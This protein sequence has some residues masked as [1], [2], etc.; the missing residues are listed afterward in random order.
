MLNRPAF[1]VVVTFCAGLS[2]APAPT[3]WAQAEN[4]ATAAE[5]FENGLADL[6]NGE[7]EAARDQ[8]YRVDPMQLP[9]E[10]RVRLYEALKQLDEAAGNGDAPVLD[11]EATPDAPDTME[12][13]AVE[14]VDPE[15]AAAQAAQADRLSDANATRAK[16]F[17][18]R[19]A[20]ELAAGDIDAAERS[21]EAARDLDA[22]LGWFDQ[23]RLESQLAVIADQ[24]S[25][26]AAAKAEAAEQAQAA[27]A[28]SPS[29]A[30]AAEVAVAEAEAARTEARTAM[31][32]A[33]AVRRTDIPP[34][35]RDLLVQAQKAYAMDL[36]AN[37]AEA[38][39]KGYH[40]LAIN[41][42]NQASQLDPDNEQIATELEAARSAA[43]ADEAPLSPL[44]EERQLA[45]LRFQAAETAYDARMNEAREALGS[46]Q[47]DAA[48]DAVNN[49]KIVL[50]RN[51]SLYTTAGYNQARAAANDLAVSIQR[52]Q[53]AATQQQQLDDERE[54]ERQESIAAREAERERRETTR[55]LFRDARDLQ[56]Q[57]RYE[58]ALALINQVLALD[59]QNV[60]AH[61]VQMILEDMI[62]LRDQADFSR[63]RNLMISRQTT[64][65][66]E[67]TIP[68]DD[69]LVYPSDWPQLT[70]RRLEALDVTGGES[71]QNR[72]AAQKLD[73]PVPINFEANP[74]EAVISYLRTTTGVNIFVNWPA[75]NLEG[76]E[77]DMP[78]TL[79][80]SDVSARN[81]LEKVIQLANAGAGGPLNPATFSI[82]DG[83][84]EISTQSELNRTTEARVYDIRDLLVQVPN[85]EDAPE[86]E[87][88]D[89]LESG[90]TGGGGGGGGGSIFGDSE[91]ED[92][93]DQP[94]RQELIDQILELIQ[95]SVG[96]PDEWLNLDS[97]IRELN[98]NLIIKTTPQNHRQ[99]VGVLGDLRE[100]R[101][102]QINVEARFLL[103]DNNFLEEF[104]IDLDFRYKASGKFAP[105]VVEQDSFNIAQRVAST[106]TPS[107]FLGGD[108]I[109]PPNA[110]SLGV[111]FI[112]DLEVDLL[113]NATQ[114]HNRSLTLT[115]PRVTFFNGQR[116]YVLVARQ[117]AFISD[118]EAV[119]DANAFDITVSTV[120][121]GVVLDVEGT[122][123][124]DRRYVTMTM[125][126]SLA[127]LAQIPID[128]IQ[129]FGASDGGDGGAGAVFEG[130]IQL[131]ELEVTQV[132]STVSVPDRGTLLLGGQRLVG[133]VEIEAGVPVLSKLPVLN[134]LFT[135]NSVVKDERTL[136]I[137]IKPT[138][139][140]QSEQE[141]LLF[142]GL[143]DDP[144]K[145][146]VGNTF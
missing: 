18:D 73:T 79:Q 7:L 61:A 142:P 145:F 88:S 103:V 111:S 43:V 86:F 109:A 112:D 89:A 40:D 10:Q 12:Q 134:R 21:L 144:A 146:N 140:L 15:L 72:E 69:L 126:P 98:G 58:E 80:L 17:L 24:R 54:R 100:Q 38:Q 132:R 122:V 95:D 93:D 47:Y 78:I 16:A 36:A 53:L 44:E 49:A 110:L 50:D 85:F 133:E 84:V 125:R 23:Q 26:I 139:I 76:I 107:R 101:A 62:I 135:N 20:E 4:G 77:E 102:T 64:L 92:D 117:F 39:S 106:L 138:I 1:A 94:T 116:A 33:A 6:L 136:L 97:T 127:T 71:R 41:M 2:L 108:G 31:E 137:L 105:T 96:T 51:A 25:A 13:P 60:E 90:G 28:T 67:A 52:Q 128:E 130:T 115:A 119:P 75:L 70:Q 59:P 74:L 8:L 56:R 45:D 19:A 37:A 131:P 48:L 81:A 27:A 32:D 29:K 141:E 143:N 129:I 113:I 83:V 91:S 11:V 66:L 65:N 118:L 104:G 63:R 87:L 55:A 121:S 82:I 14:Q 124:A 9:K 30:P 3:L 120:N 22:N 57:M 5:L 34:A 35:S 114:A 46:G 42:Y 123:S 68:Y 99:I